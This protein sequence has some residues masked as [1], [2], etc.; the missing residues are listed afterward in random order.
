MATLRRGQG[1]DLPASPTPTTGA[2]GSSTRSQDL[3]HL[4]HMNWW[5]ADICIDGEGSRTSSRM[6]KSACATFENNHGERRPLRIAPPPKSMP[7]TATPATKTATHQQWR[8]RQQVNPH[9]PPPPQPQ[10][11][12]TATP[13]T[14]IP[15]QPQR[16]TEHHH[17]HNAPQPDPPANNHRR[18]TATTRS[19]PPPAVHNIANTDGHPHNITERRA[20]T[21]RRYHTKESDRHRTP[22]PSLPTVSAYDNDDGRHTEQAPPGAPRPG[23]LEP[24][25]VVAM[26]NLQA[27]RHQACDN[28]T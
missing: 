20:S 26:I 6:R 7:K 4:W 21:P 11:A 28:S 14:T 9:E 18:T 10:R 3:T 27:R 8:C 16:Q 1:P 22:N 12:K 17:H 5:S 13:R 23:A 19:T 2:E 15:I 25:N 24:T